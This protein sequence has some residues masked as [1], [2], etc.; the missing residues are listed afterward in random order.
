MAVIVEVQHLVKG[1]SLLP[2]FPWVVKDVETVEGIPFFEL[3]GGHTGLCRFV[4]GKSKMPEVT[5]LEHLKKLRTDAC[6]QASLEASLQGEPQCKPPFVEVAVPDVEFAGGWQFAPATSLKIKWPTTCGENIKLELS[7]ANLNHVRRAC[8][9]SRAPR[10]HVRRKPWAPEFKR[11][12]WMA[13]DNGFLAQRP[14]EFRF[15][16]A[17]DDIDYARHLAYRWAKAEDMPSSDDEGE[18]IGGAFLPDNAGIEKTLST[19]SERLVQC[20]D[21]C[22]DP[23]SGHRRKEKRRIASS[24]IV[25]SR[26]T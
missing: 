14:D 4:T 20:S 22:T 10:P 21:H 11:C 1:G 13:K 19:D 18:F 15:F 7:A 9:S 24:R 25:D 26:C 5:W 16:D 8:L 12:Q 23:Q 6:M 3:D 2:A 17:G